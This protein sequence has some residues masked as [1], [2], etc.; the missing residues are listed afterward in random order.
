MLLLAGTGGFI[1]YKWRRDAERE[2]KSGG[3]KA[4][5]ATTEMKAL[6]AQMNPH[7]IFNS[8][9]SISQY[10]TTNDS[11]TADYFTIKFSKLMRDDT[12]EF[13]KE[14]TLTEDL[15]ALEL[16]TRNSNQCEWKKIHLW[17]KYRQGISTPT[18][19]TF[20]HS[21]FS[22]C[23]K[24]YL[25]RFFQLNENGKIEISFSKKDNMLQCVIV[26]N[27]IGRSASEANH[28]IY[29][30][31]NKNPWEWT[32]QRHWMDLLNKLSDVKASVQFIDLEKGLKVI[33]Q[34]PILLTIDIWFEQFWLTMNNIA[35]TD[36][37]CYF[38]MTTL[39]KW[40][41]CTYR[42][43]WRMAW[44]QSEKWNLI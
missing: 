2:T 3:N 41:F 28:S 27:G 29:G 31:Q 24:R 6:R 32:L 11:K 8:L 22:L 34:L 39:P 23:R 12:G 15:E 1:L 40:K 42:I 10:I 17:H 4:D 5:I 33:L 35:L 18:Q 20:R 14:V 16:Y 21:S 37:K 7:F 19:H 26:D 43:Q 38:K 13:W 44:M 36:C 9:N 25:A 30:N